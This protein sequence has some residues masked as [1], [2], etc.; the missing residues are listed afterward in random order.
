MT[1]LWTLYVKKMS[2]LVYRLLGLDYSAGC[3][4]VLSVV[5]CW[6]F[7]Y[8]FFIH[9]HEFFKK[10]SIT[11]YELCEF[12]LYIGIVVDILELVMNIRIFN[13]F[14]EILKSKWDF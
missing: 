11:C 10:F 6:E 2:W 13:E 4:F 5:Q 12:F 9:L 3:V 1:K 14:S 8:L 7:L